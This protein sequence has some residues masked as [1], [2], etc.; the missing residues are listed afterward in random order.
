MKI[1]PF[2]KLFH[3]CGLLAG[4]GLMLATGAIAQAQDTGMY[5]TFK[6]AKAFTMRGAFDQTVAGGSTVF[7]NEYA[8]EW[9]ASGA[10]GTRI[11]YFILTTGVGPSLSSSYLMGSVFVDLPLTEQ[12]TA[13]AGGGIG[14]AK[15]NLPTTTVNVQSSPDTETHEIQTED[16]YAFAFK[17]SGGIAYEMMENVHLIADYSYFKTSD[18]DVKHLLTVNSETPL[19]GKQTLTTN[20]VSHMLG[21]GL[22]YEF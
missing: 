3:F 17:L 9:A 10:I 21:V 7:L 15:P 20:I 19:V 22:R 4:I 18:F 12:L 13:F 16:V 2:K 14:I 6:G 5:L 8:D 1:A 11:N